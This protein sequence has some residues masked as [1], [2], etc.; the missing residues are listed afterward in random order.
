MILVMKVHKLR[1]PVYMLSRCL[2]VGQCCRELAS[3]IRV[4]M[5]RRWEQP[6]AI[7]PCSMYMQVTAPINNDTSLQMH[8]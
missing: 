6:S 4:L 1:V 3:L 2:L 8:T 7:R 5:P